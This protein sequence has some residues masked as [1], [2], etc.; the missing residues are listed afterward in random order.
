MLSNSQAF[1]TFDLDP[2][3]EEMRDM[4]GALGRRPTGA[5]SGGNRREK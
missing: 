4:V 5:A 2:M 1:M 3:V